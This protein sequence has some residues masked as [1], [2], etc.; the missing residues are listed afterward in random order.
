MQQYLNRPIFPFEVN[1]GSQVARSITYDLRQTGLGFGAE[2]FVPT[3]K[4]DVTG[5]EFELYHDGGDDV[6]AF[7][8]FA[9]SLVGRLQG[10][11]LPCPLQAAVFYKA[12]SA[13][14]I[15]IENSGYAQFWKARPDQFLL[16]KF[17]DGTC[18]GAQILT[19]S[20]G[21]ASGTWPA[22]L[23]IP[24][25][26]LDPEGEYIILTAPVAAPPANWAGTAIAKLHYV[27]FAADEETMGMD[28]E[29]TGAMKI[30]VVELPL[31]YTRAATG[32]QP[33]YLYR[34][35]MKAPV[36]TTWNYT[37][38]AAAVASNGVLYQPWAMSHGAIKQS[39]DG[40][41]NPVSVTA[42]WDPSHPFS[43]LGG[44]PPGAV[45]W[46]TIMRCYLGTP[47]NVITLWAGYVDHMSDGTDKVAATCQS[48]LNWL[49]SRLPRFYIGTT[50][51]WVLY[52]VNTCMVPRAYFETTVTIQTVVQSQVPQLQCSF[53]FG[54]QTAN[55]QQQNWFQG[56]TLEVGVGLTYEL[57]SVVA[58]EWVPPAGETPGYLLLTLA[59]PL[60]KNGVNAPCQISAGC[61]HTSNGQNGCTIK[62][63][64]FQ[65][66]G[67]MVD[68]P[69]NNLSLQ[70]VN[71]SNAMG[72]KK[73]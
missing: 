36:A 24:I 72:G 7:E 29:G 41:S 9:D 13:Q 54:F 27:R 73:A 30:S 28:C 56:G 23:N 17:G 19:V 46:V 40:N 44:T 34:V 15:Q 8:S 69:E 31:E 22:N 42:K 60:K 14:V 18:A 21:D 2:Y 66:F 70:G 55:W 68:C 65:N 67:G 43:I 11:W 39:T 26:E 12:L 59:A 32:L 64:N 63:N 20:T 52:D 45:M 10:F 47:N 57:R 3:A 50:C 25:D 53:N 48:R 1:W 37:S 5:W 6:L 4:Y 16:F 38:F 58:S 35:Y 51:N 49:K 33:I 61:D 62:F 71:T